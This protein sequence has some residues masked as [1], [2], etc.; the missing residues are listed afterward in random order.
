MSTVLFRI[1]GLAL[2]ALL[3]TFSYWHH[4]LRE[5]TGTLLLTAAGICGICMAWSPVSEALCEIKNR[6]RSRMECERVYKVL[7]RW[8]GETA[9]NAENVGY[10]KQLVRILD[11][12]VSIHLSLY[13][14]DR[15]RREMR[16]YK[17]YAER[18]YNFEPKKL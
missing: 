18:S 5:F 9:I 15:D 3:M 8:T 14:E 13:P 12:T 4:F 16:H 10:Y 6:A 1:L 17:W 7:H 2:L 11:N